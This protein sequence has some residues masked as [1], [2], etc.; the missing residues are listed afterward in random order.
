M[1]KQGIEKNNLCADEKFLNDAASL[2]Y[3]LNT[4]GT[5]EQFNHPGDTL[6]ALSFCLL[7]EENYKFIINKEAP[8]APVPDGHWDMDRSLRI[9]EKQR[10]RQNLF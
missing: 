3:E 7:N 1:V 4:A 2:V 9:A 5:K 10:R 6:M 8:R